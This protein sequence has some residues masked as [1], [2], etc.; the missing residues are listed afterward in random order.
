VVL[1]GGGDPT[2]GGRFAA[3]GYPGTASLRALAG[4]LTGV[5]RVLVDDS[6]YAG[7][8][9]GPGWKPSYVS[10]GDVAPVSALAVDEGRTAKTGPRTSDPALSAGRQL[11]ELLHVRA[12]VA[13]TKAPSG[14]TV[15]SS[16]DSA[17]VPELVESMLTRS[18]NDLAEAL[19]R[20]V[21]LASGQP[22][23]FAGAAAATAAVLQRLGVPGFAL[24]D[25]SGL[26]P[27]DRVQPRA[28][29]L[30]LAKAAGDPTYAPLLSGLPVAGFDG[31]LGKRYRRPPSSAAA[32]AVRAKTGTLNGVSALAGLVT[33]RSSGVLAFDITA[34]RV[35]IGTTL[36]AE[37]ALDR[38]AAA[39]AG[40][41]CN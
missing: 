33:T 25:S 1:V 8:V 23:S 39:L 22:A 7:P 27:L 26:S 3:P 14:A 35:P 36:A 37:A 11:A 38:V 34:D 18:D 6:L 2:L 17:P 10:D 15:L 9:L 41:G 16:V 28:V 30:L 29:A 31:T 32:G 21:A 5:T 13:R 40:C 24:R 20:Q 12:P 4:G 19:G